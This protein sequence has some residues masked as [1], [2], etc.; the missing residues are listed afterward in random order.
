MTTTGTRT[1]EGIWSKTHP[2]A[3][4][5]AG[6]LRLIVRSFEY[7]D[8]AEYL[9]DA[10]R[11]IHDVGGA[12]SV[13]VLQPAAGQ[14][15]IVARHGDPPSPPQEM[16]ADSIDREQAVADGTW[17]VAPLFRQTTQQM[18]LCI[19]GS[20]AKTDWVANIGAAVGH[21]WSE[22]KSRYQLNR[23]IRRLATILK[24]ANEWNKTRE[25]EPLL[26]QMAEAATQL[27]EADRASIFLW[28]RDNKMLVGR[29]AL[30]VEG[31]ELRIPD[32]M[33][34]VG[35]VVQTGKPQRVRRKDP[36]QQIH[37]DVDH[38]VGYATENI[39][40]VPLVSAKGERFGAFEILN[41]LKGEFTDED[42]EGLVELA[43]HA[44]TALA[45]TQELEDL[46]S[47]NRRLVDEAA[48]T[49][50]MIGE[51]PPI[52]ALRSTIRK[53]AATDLAVLMLGENGTGKEVASQLLHY[54]SP[55]RSQP[56]VAVNCA[57]IPDTLLESELFGH[58]KGAF[59]DARETRVGKFELAAS[60]TL[61][62]DEIGDLSLSGQAKM[63]RVL[64]EK[65]IVRVGGSTPIL[66]GARII[67]ATNQ[68][69]AQM[70][71]EK[72]FREDL[73]F[74]LN[75]VTLELPPLRDRGDDIVLL[76]DHFLADFSR[77]A[78]RKT[79]RLTSAARKRLRGHG[80]PGNVRELRNLIERLVYMT[81]SDKIEAEE[82]E[83]IIAPRAIS[84]MDVPDDASL[85]DATSKF[86][87]QF[88]RTA[89][90]RSGGNVS[91]AATRL[92]LHR[93]NLYRK[94]RQLGMK[95]D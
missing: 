16:L 65:V 81:S 79:P 59:T 76:T 92:G 27:L 93:S 3:D 75:V 58:E 18:V 47:A 56:F 74:R 33:G 70:V 13:A 4:T 32:D 7:A 6:A 21:G 53:I 88:I 63:L 17:I 11:E 41:K 45:T 34:V 67:A 23:R 89:I 91:E 10:V 71:S 54:L 68:D 51:S 42:E 94:M 15:T 50:R 29:P 22:V 36:E 60:G 61:L 78:G 14:W 83:F 31:G 82:L 19:N 12:R 20:S 57:A 77:K 37:R 87:Q 25:T 9:S 38:R 30:G 86:Q 85:T 43:A 24:I 5:F 72:R 46:V 95:A 8:A 40:C 62:L 80:W 55:R 44:A 2:A 28:D 64:E 52:E 35:K 49:I 26:V 73:Y 48:D 39:L 84:A 66:T 1:T 90:D 69:L